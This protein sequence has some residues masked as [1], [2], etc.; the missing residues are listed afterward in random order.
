VEEFHGTRYQSGS[1]CLINVG[2]VFH[3]LHSLFFLFSYLVKP[4]FFKQ[5]LWLY[6]VALLRKFCFLPV[7]WWRRCMV[8]GTKVDF[9]PVGSHFHHLRLLFHSFSFS[10][11]FSFSLI[12]SLHEG[13]W[14]WLWVWVWWDFTAHEGEWR[15]RLVWE[16]RDLLAAHW[17]LWP[18][19]FSLGF[20]QKLKF[21]KF[22]HAFQ[23]ALKM[24]FT[25]YQKLSNF[26][27][28]FRAFGSKIAARHA[29]GSLKWPSSI[30]IFCALIK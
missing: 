21:P 11:S 10:F 23:Q 27:P 8:T 15:W 3:C 17:L 29:G 4:R 16:W 13:K 24:L 25:G 2:R 20:G 30:F 5:I 19:S 14:Q 7:L 6:T 9:F 18:E 22:L 26:K 28:F 12:K 1:F